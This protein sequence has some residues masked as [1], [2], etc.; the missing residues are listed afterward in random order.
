MKF[1]YPGIC[2]SC[3][4]ANRA[5]SFLLESI[6]GPVSQRGLNG[7]YVN[8]N[9]SFVR[10]ITGLPEEM[11]T[12]FSLSEFPKIVPEGLEEI[13]FIHDGEFLEKGETITTKQGSTNL[14]LIL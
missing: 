1:I 8:C 7:T 5:A 2:L 12:G 13:Y 3:F 9:E 10:Q 11:V 14:Y 6:P 4:C